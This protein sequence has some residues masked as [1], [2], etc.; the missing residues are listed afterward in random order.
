MAE[1]E[2][3]KVNKAKRGGKYF[4]YSLLFICIL[5]LISGTYNAFI[6]FQF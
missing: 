6:Y 5:K 2:T 3:S 4:D 1:V